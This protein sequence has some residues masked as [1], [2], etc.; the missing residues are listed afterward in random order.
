MTNRFHPVPQILSS[1]LMLL[2][3]LAVI[4]TLIHQF[5]RNEWRHCLGTLHS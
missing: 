2:G 1:R 4:L 5:F 3:V